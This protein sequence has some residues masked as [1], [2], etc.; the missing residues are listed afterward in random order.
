MRITLTDRSTVP[1]SSKREYLDNGYLKVPGR[2]ARTGIQQYMASELGLNDRSPSE[3]VNVYRP[4]N[5]VFKPES[6]ASYDN[7][8]IT[9]EHPDRMVDAKTYQDVSV[10][11][12][13]SEGRQDGDW[14][15]SDLLFKSQNAIDAINSGK[16]ELSV[17]YTAEYIPIQ[18]VTDD[19][20]PY[21]FE[22]RDI[23]VNHVALCDTARAGS[24][25]R[26]FDTKKERHMHQVILDS[27]EKVTVG[28]EAAQIRI[29]N[30]ID[31]MKKRV[32]DAEEAAESAEAAQEAAEAKADAA[33]AKAEEAACKVEELE[34][35]LEEAAAGEAMDSARKIA[36]KD[37][38]CDSK[39]SVE[40]KR[41]ALD[42]AGIKCRKH[43]SWD[44]AP[45]GYIHAYFD[46]MEES[47]EETDDDDEEWSEKEAKDSHRRLGKELKDSK[48]Q[49]AQATRDAVRNEWMQKRHARKEKK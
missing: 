20:T 24:L 35:Q 7:C 28:D 38:V 26:I 37:F 47:A 39:K 31:S 1:V 40:I 43:G 5:E 30:S 44:K 45:D 36:G 42:S 29:Q 10:G 41:A 11:S 18:G 46:A 3:L 2:V 48:P 34:E 32:K 27:G 19:G 12:V 25:A 13:I 6:L 23:K 16:A 4:P 21:E 33:E 9:V 17:G 15:C 49:G 22:Q 14:V 8:D